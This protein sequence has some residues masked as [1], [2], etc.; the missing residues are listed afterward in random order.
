MSKVVASLDTIQRTLASLA[1]QHGVPGASLAVFDGDGEIEAVTGVAN[2]NTGVEVTPQTLFQI[3]SNTKL[4]TTTLVLQLVD[5]GQVD[6][7][8][9]VRSY[10][11]DF[12]LADA[13]AAEEITVRQLLTHTSGM[14]GDYFDDFGRGDDCTALYVESLRTL[15]QVH[16][17]G[18]RYSYCNT[19]FVVAGRIVEVVRGKPFH[20]VLRDELLTPIG[21]RSTTVLL[22]EMIGFRYAVGHGGGRDGSRATVVPQIMMAR[23]QGP[24]GSLTSATARDVLKL[25]RL[26]LDRGE[27]PDG[28]RVLSAKSVHAMQQPQV[29]IPGTATGNT[30]MGLGWMIDQWGNERVIGH[31]GGTLGQLSFLQVL[32]DRRFGVCLLTNSGNGGLLWRDLGG[33]LFDELAGVTMPRVPQPPAAPHELDLS[34]YVGRYERLSHLT[35]IDVEDGQLLMTMTVTGTIAEKMGGEPQKVRLRPIDAERFFVKMPSGDAMV[36]FSDFDKNG[37]PA[38]LFMGRASPRVATPRAKRK[39]AAKAPKAAKKA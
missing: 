39:A 36:T 14:Q 35:E 34:R 20:E 6:L 4:Y 19:G 7:D 17:P 27:A 38:Y 16:P 8:S 25:V 32:P 28:T 11:D 5:N 18:E 21:A 37:R 3:G 33:W 10:L 12:E 9:P 31:G 22:E 15:T 29:P 24:A 26:H 23:A 13:K 1:A 30:H 2:A